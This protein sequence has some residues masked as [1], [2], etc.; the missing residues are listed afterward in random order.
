[1]GS[2]QVEVVVVKIM[3]VQAVLEVIVL[4]MLLMEVQVVEE[5]QNQVYY[6]VQEK[7]ILLQSAVV[8]VV[9]ALLAQECQVLKVLIHQYQVQELQQ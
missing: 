8:E 9:E 3:V 2:S 4:L 6:L 1:M 7:F 5:V